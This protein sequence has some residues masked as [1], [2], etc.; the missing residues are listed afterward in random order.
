MNAQS[1]HWACIPP[2]TAAGYKHQSLLSPTKGFV[3]ITDLQGAQI[4]GL[5]LEGLPI[6]TAAFS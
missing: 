5:G 1:G 4:F 6:L 2:E 3:D